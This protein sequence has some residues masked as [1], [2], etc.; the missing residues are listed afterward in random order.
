MLGVDAKIDDFTNNVIQF[1]Q[2]YPDKKI[3]FIEVDCFGGVL[4]YKI[5]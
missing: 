3:A 1:S 5:K 4:S 2:F